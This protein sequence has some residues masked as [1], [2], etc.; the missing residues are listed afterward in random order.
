MFKCATQFKKGRES[1]HSA[2]FYSNCCKGV[3][4]RSK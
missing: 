3:V 1:L 2:N 4:S